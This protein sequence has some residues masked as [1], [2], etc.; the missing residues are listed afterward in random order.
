MIPADTIV[1]CAGQISVR[2][3]ADELEARGQSVHVIGGAALAGEL[4]A[5]RAILEGALVGNQV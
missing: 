5:K 4:D 3:L 1:V 2:G